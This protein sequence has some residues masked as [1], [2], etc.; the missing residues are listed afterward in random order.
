MKHCG[1]E[2]SFFLMIRRPPRSTLFP[3][4]TLYDASYSILY[5]WKQLAMDAQN[6]ELHI[7]GSISDKEI[8][9]EDLKKY[10]QNVYAINPEAEFNR[11]PITKIKG[12]PM[13][14]SLLVLKGR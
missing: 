11:A 8:L 2:R 10:L 6:D 1:V 9:T 4:T 14:I 3:Y 5:V 13:D 7:F 12:L